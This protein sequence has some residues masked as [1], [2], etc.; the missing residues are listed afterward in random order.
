MGGFMQ[1]QGH[2]QV[3]SAMLDDSLNPQEALD[4]PRWMVMD[5]D[6]AGV[7]A[8]EDGI[9]THTAARLAELGH[10]VRPIVGQ[11]RALFGSGQIIRRDPASGVLYGGSDPRKDGLVAAY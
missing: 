3:I 9:P 10:T 7:I 1:P 2:M 5:G 6:P 8:L 4:R 11:G